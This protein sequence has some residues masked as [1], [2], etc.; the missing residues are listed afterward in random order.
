MGLW[1]SVFL[2][3]E[4]VGLPFAGPLAVLD[5][6]QDFYRGQDGV[7]KGKWPNDLLLRDKKC[8]GTLVERRASGTVI[9]IGIN[10]LQ[11]PDHFP[12]ELHGKATSFQAE[13]GWTPGRARFLRSVLH[14]L[15]RNVL[16]LRTDPSGADFLSR[17]WFEICRMQGRSVS[18]RGGE[19]VIEGVTNSGALFVRQGSDLTTV[20][21]DDSVKVLPL[22][23]WDAA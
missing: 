11:Q 10:L 13:F 16:M 14:A 3:N 19:G 12:E 6:F 5:A 21:F 9:G 17:R 23:Q 1:F 4:V 18:W 15:D 22:N 7:L 20:P 2:E 8:C